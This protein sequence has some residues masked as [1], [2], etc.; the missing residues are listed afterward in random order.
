M[1]FLIDNWM[2]LICSACVGA[3]IGIGTYQWFS[4]PKSEKIKNIK[5]WLLYAV[6]CAQAELGTGTGTLKLR[7]VYDQA[8]KRFP[9][10]QVVPFNTFKEW[11]DEALERMEDML[12][13]SEET[14]A[15]VN[16]GEA[17]EAD[18]EEMR[19]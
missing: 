11:V 8:L 13:N 3:A 2:L 1:Q 16:H 10:V 17:R 12:D 9:W 7:S 5:E 19:G 4:K 15:L 6:T 18:N 14:R